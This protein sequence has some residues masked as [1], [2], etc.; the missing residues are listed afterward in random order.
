MNTSGQEQVFKALADPTRRAMLN[1]LRESDRS[2]SELALPFDMSQPA[3]SQHLRILR[4]AGLVA[5]RR[6]GR[7]QVYS[8]DPAP[9]KEVYDW[10]GH[11]ERFWDR[12]LDALGAYLEKMNEKRPEI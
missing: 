1:L 4:D 6:S 8:L 5:A 7:Q 3:I 2:A 10:L 9:L 12:K 11:F